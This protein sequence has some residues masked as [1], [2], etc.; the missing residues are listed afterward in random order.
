MKILKV[1]HLPQELLFKLKFRKLKKR[2]QKIEKL[3]QKIN[4][5]NETR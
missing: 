1:N 5:T 3:L 4:D 2:R